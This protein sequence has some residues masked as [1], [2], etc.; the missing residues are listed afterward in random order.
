MRGIC[1]AGLI[2]W[3]EIGS[4]RLDKN[5][6]GGEELTLHLSPKGRHSNISFPI[7][8]MHRERVAEILAADS[9]LERL[10]GEL[11]DVHSL[12]HRDRTPS[13]PG[14]PGRMNVAIVLAMASRPVTGA[15][16]ML[17]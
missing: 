14:G 13:M 16:G 17:S 4:Y 5:P 10:V 12:C 9:Q 6:E 1:F 7:P 15:K 8:A 11:E 3:G 2:K